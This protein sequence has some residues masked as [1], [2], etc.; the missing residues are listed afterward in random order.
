MGIPLT[1]AELSEESKGHYLPFDGPGIEAVFI[2]CYR[3]V[4]HPPNQ[5]VELEFRPNFKP[6]TTT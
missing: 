5:G 2:T 6:P 4:K 1:I 3:I